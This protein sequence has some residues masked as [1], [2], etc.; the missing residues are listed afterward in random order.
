MIKSLDSAAPTGSALGNL[1]SAS[2]VAPPDGLL[3][4]NADAVMGKENHKGV[5]YV[6]RDGDGVILVAAH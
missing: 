6:V 3:K 2:W 5:A 1:S 4:L